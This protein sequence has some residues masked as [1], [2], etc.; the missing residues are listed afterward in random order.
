MNL[1]VA[2]DLSPASKLVITAVQ[3]VA[4]VTGAHV[5]VVHVAEPEPDFM[6]FEAGPEVVRDQLA[7]EYRQQHQAVQA[8]AEGLREHG[9]KATALLIRGP[10]A[11]ATIREAE[12][13]DAELIVVG[14]HGRSA[15]YD[16]LV[17]SYSADILRKS[18]IPVL[19]VPTRD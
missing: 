4:E 19:V 8:L 18:R 12:R 5:Y 6:G 3:R 1:L 16:V 7:A 15:I 13:L 10:T 17:G 11:A 2:V 14:S 9:I